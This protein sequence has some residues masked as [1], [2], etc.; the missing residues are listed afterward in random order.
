MMRTPNFCWKRSI[1]L[2]GTAEPPQITMRSDEKSRSCASLYRSTSFQIVGTAPLK[3]G[4]SLS[5]S[6]HSGSAC[7]KRE[8]RMK[9]APAVQPE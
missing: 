1:R 8:G 7:R 2:R 6:L 5:I 9:S 4:R 3:V